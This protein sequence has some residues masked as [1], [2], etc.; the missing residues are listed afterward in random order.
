MIE[1]PP[2]S[3][4]MPPLNPPAPAINYV[5][6]VYAVPDFD[7]ALANDQDRQTY[8]D[9]SMILHHPWA[10]WQVK[11]FRLTPATYTAPP[12]PDPP[13][14]DLVDH[15]AHYTSHPSG[16]EPIQITRHESFCRG[17]AIKYL[18]RAGRKDPD[19]RTDLLKARRYID[20]ELE[21][22]QQRWSPESPGA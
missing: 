11:N 3:A 20:F 10:V 21:D 1:P 15:P 4:V 17:N 9:L 18:L 12:D 14:A 13:T 6:V 19:P 2:L 5:T 16:I 7:V 8:D 22:L